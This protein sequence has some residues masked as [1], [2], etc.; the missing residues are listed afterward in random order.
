MFS[1]GCVQHCEVALFVLNT[2]RQD[3]GSQW[4]A[5]WQWCQ[6]S[7]WGRGGEEG[8]RLLRLHW[9][10]HHKECPSSASRL[11]CCPCSPFF[12]LS[13]SDLKLFHSFS[14]SVFER[15]SKYSK[16]DVAKAIDL[17]MKGD[18]ENCLT[19]VGKDYF[20]SYIITRALIYILYIIWNLFFLLCIVKCA[21]CRPAFFAEKLYLAMKV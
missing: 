19:A 17:Q 10:P 12:C 13:L 21:G 14:P 7:V 11:A 8:Q 15:Y 6:G 4:A 20:F 3:W 1:I 9:N 16:V 5:D 2:G 18:I